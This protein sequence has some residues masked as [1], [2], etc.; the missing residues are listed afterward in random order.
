MT[1][2]SKK[3]VLQYRILDSR[4]SYDMTI[5]QLINSN[6]LN[7]I[8]QNIDETS[9]IHSVFLSSQTIDASQFLQLLNFFVEIFKSWFPTLMAPQLIIRILFD[10]NPS[11]V[12]NY[13]TLS[14][15]ISNQKYTRKINQALYNIIIH[16]FIQN[17]EKVLS[18]QELLKK[19]QIEIKQI[20]FYSDLES[21]QI[22]ELLSDLVFCNKGKNSIALFLNINQEIKE[23]KKKSKDQII[24]CFSKKYEAILKR[25]TQKY[26]Y[27]KYFKD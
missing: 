9:L 18:F 20:E 19:Q 3:K 10:S 25:Y 7:S 12:Q 16:N 6:C 24:N 27:L 17:S 1:L 21:K 8:I 5:F 4:N 15:D 22:L 11:L 13:F 2:E 26:K 23:K 14:Y